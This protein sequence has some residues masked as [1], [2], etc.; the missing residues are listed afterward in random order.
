[1]SLPTLKLQEGDNI[2]AV[3]IS[4]G[5]A[6]EGAN[7]YGSW[8]RYELS[9]DGEDHSFFANE[10]VHGFLKGYTPGSAVVLTGNPNPK[11]KGV[12]VNVTGTPAANGSATP[13]TPTPVVRKITDKGTEIR[14]MWAIKVAALSLGDKPFGR[15]EV[16]RRSEVLLEILSEIQG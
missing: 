6:G 10:R 16:Q 14:H 8:F 12:V 3:L 11:G 1:M 13:E 9:V 15:E 5:P 4:D 2:N 7:S